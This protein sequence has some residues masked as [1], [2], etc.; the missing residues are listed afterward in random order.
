MSYQDWQALCASEPE[1]ANAICA[2][3][4]GWEHR[5]DKR[6]VLSRVWSDKTG[7]VMAFR[8]DWSPITDHNHAAM[9]VEKVLDQHR[10]PA[11]LSA[12]WEII[13]PQDAAVFGGSYVAAQRP[14]ALLILPASDLSYCACVA[15]EKEEA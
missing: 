11:L 15:L 12:I 10:G 9:M 5:S 8:S 1:K 2:E 13:A 4:M 6:N 7:R 3:R 14:I